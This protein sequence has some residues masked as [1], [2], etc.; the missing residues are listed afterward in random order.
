MNAG[1]ITQDDLMAANKC[2]RLSDLED[3]LRKNGIRFLYGKSGI[4]TT[5]DALNA[6]MGLQSGQDI[7]KKSD[8]FEI[9]QIGG[10]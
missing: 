8:E 7:A 3:I 2:K 5:M 6:A 1:I 10:K 9:F 4:Y